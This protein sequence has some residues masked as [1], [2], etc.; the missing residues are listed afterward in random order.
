MARVNSDLI[1]KYI[2]II[3]R[4]VGFVHKHFDGQLLELKHSPLET[5]LAHMVTTLRDAADEISTFYEQLEYG[6]ALRKIMEL[7]DLIN[8]NFDTYKPWILS[9]DNRLV[10]LNDVCHFTL[11]A[12]KLLTIYLKPV[13]PLTAQKVETLLNIP[14]Q[15]WSDI[16]K[17]LEP[18]HRIDRYTHLMQR[19]DHKQLDALFEPAV[20]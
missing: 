11:N 20:S 6:K 15:T 5:S 10:D 3:S 7:T 16:D 1:G 2:N 19:V 13:L 8:K 18:G 17:P 9:K 14:A 12:F 4:V